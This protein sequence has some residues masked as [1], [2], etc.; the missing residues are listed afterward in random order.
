MG[1][2]LGE[3]R[4]RSP[5]HKVIKRHARRCKSSTTDVRLVGKTVYYLNDACNQMPRFEVEQVFRGRG[6]ADWIER[7]IKKGTR[8][9]EF[10]FTPFELWRLKIIFE[11]ALRERSLANQVFGCNARDGRG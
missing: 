8:L 11:E 4:V 7:V 3:V 2:F 9:I 6:L 10:V 1:P 5:S